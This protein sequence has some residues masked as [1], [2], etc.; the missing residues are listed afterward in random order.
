MKLRN[1]KSNR[2][3]APMPTT[4]SVHLCVLQ[5]SSTKTPISMGNLIAASQRSLTHCHINCLLCVY[6]VACA[7]LNVLA[8]AE[9]LHCMS[10]DKARQAKMSRGSTEPLIPQDTIEAIEY[11]K[12]EDWRPIVS[13]TFPI[14]EVNEAL[15]YLREGKALGRIVL[16]HD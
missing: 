5:D 9:Q 12:S 15:K 11:V 10:T 1:A 16:T 3:V 8:H 7:V 6:V 13:D 14:E 2:Q 4:R